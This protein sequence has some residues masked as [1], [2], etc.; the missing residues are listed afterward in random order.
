MEKFLQ[1]SIQCQWIEF[2]TFRLKICF[3]W[4]NSWV[5]INE[6]LFMHWGLWKKIV[7][8]NLIYLWIFNY[9]YALYFYFNFFKLAPFSS[10]F[11]LFKEISSIHPIYD[12]WVII[13]IMENSTMINL[14]ITIEKWIKWLLE[15]LYL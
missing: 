13:K 7:S 1:Q 9:M 2:G 14:Q 3:Q 6:D 11:I 10:L 8:C 15:M 12:D 5:L 4:W